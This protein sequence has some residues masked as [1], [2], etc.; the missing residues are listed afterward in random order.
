MEKNSFVLYTEDIDNLIE[1][2]D[3]FQIGKLIIAINKYVKTKQM[4][5]FKFEPVLSMAF[6]F[7]KNKLDR[8]I[9]KW[10]KTKQA[11]SEAGKKSGEKKKA[12]IKKSIDKYEE[13]QT[14]QT[15]QTNVDFV[16]QNKQNKQSQTNQTVN[17]NDY[18]N[19]IDNVNNKKE[20]VKKEKDPQPKQ[21]VAIVPKESSQ[22]R[23]Y[24]YFATKYKK[25]V[26]IEYLSKRSDFINLAELI[27]TY[28]E[29]VVRQKIDL[30]ETGCVN[31]VFW[32]AKESGVNSFTV[33]KLKSQWNEI[34]PQYTKEQLKQ[35]EEQ[36][37]EE[38]RMKRVL[39]EAQ[40]LREERSK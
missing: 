7:I 21:Q 5:D 19:V 2:L 20:K 10:E 37:K 40:K 29:D 16:K 8:D 35:Q 31:R 34:L 23:V 33:G 38:E 24:K 28:G 4:P 39:A 11:R 13:N 36:K 32:F 30:L 9:D 15:K 1:D 14:K 6:K 17:V 26:G 12:K 25:L 18:V 27:R 3:E 22:Q